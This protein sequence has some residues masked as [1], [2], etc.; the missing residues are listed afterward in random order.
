MSNANNCYSVRNSNAVYHAD[1]DIFSSSML[2]N[3][4]ESPANFIQSL[5]ERY[6][7]SKS[8]DFGTLIHALVLEPDTVNDLVAIY[9]DDFTRTKDCLAFKAANPDR[10]C[11]T[12]REFCEAQNLAEK[13]LNE[14]FRGRKFLHFVEES[15]IEESIYYTDPVTGMKCRTRIDAKHPEF[16]IDL[17]TTRHAS[18]DQFAKDAERL[19]YDL[20]AYMYT[21]SRFLLER[22]LSPAGVD[23]KPKP[24]LLVPV[25]TEAPHNVYF[26]PASV[27]FLE[28]GKA[29]YEHALAVIKACTDVQ[30]W[31]TFGGEHEI[32]ISPWQKY[33][34]DNSNFFGASSI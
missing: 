8:T 30:S 17:K 21:L 33:N 28:N 16:T 5:L 24:F 10:Y 23:V 22:S 31:P 27:G 26:M 19:H 7:R 15:S 13:T 34:P 1:V 12:L 14:R 4:L 6:L 11:L 25:C 20:S 2:K 9:P 3:A 29:K 18:K 32:D